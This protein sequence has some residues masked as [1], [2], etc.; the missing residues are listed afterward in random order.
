[1]LLE[2]L[3]GCCVA[4][5]IVVMNADGS[6]QTRLT[7]TDAREDSPSWS[8]D[9]SRIAFTSNRDGNTG[10]YVMNKESQLSRPSSSTPCGGRGY[11]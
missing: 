5:E 3:W 11:S 7:R 6:G 2:G 10:I 9:G 4:Q 8:P 1:M